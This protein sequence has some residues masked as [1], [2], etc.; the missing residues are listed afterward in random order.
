M[1]HPVLHL[2]MFNKLNSE[3]L[4]TITGTVERQS[5]H[6]YRVTVTEADLRAG[7]IITCT[8]AGN[9]K[10]KVRLGERITEYTSGE[11]IGLMF[12]KYIYLMEY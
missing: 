6:F 2:E 12:G 8:S 10:F 1:P 11:D 4:Q 7:V 5:A 9:D 3:P